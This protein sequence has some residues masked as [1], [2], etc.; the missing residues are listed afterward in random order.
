MA[1][2]NNSPSERAKP[3][4]RESAAR[5]RAS[6][7]AMTTQDTS[8]YTHGHAVSYTANSVDGEGTSCTGRTEDVLDS[9]AG[10]A[11]ST[12]SEF[13]RR[14]LRDANEFRRALSEAC[15]CVS[16]YV[17]MV[18][19]GLL[20]VTAERIVSRN[21]RCLNASWPASARHVVHS[22]NQ[23]SSVSHQRDA[24]SGQLA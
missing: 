22:D 24:R 15:T 10:M 17:S 9:N 8:E 4:K 23:I 2:K 12:P 18:I 6:D 19:E 11:F 5:E 7:R 13:W 3:A 21:S 1:A 20:H 16:E 14:P